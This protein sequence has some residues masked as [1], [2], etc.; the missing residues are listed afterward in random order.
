MKNK[1]KFKPN[2]KFKYL[3]NKERLEKNVIIFLKFEKIKF[4]KIC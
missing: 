3:Y 4:N 1:E 2:N